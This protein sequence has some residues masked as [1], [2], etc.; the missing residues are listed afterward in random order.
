MYTVN[1]EF[2]YVSDKKRFLILILNIQIPIAWAVNNL[3]I[4]RK[5][6]FLSSRILLGKLLLITP[7]PPRLLSKPPVNN[8]SDIIFKHIVTYFIILNHTLYFVNS[9]YAISQ[10]ILAFI[11]FYLRS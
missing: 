9:V 7:P 6:D 4:F 8:M 10:F 5:V 2:N 3:M 1:R 11:V